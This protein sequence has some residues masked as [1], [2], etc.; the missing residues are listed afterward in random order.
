MANRPIFG[1]GKP[2][3]RPP[4][5]QQPQEEN[6][7]TNPYDRK[8]QANQYNRWNRLKREG[9]LGNT[10][11]GKP[12]SNYVPPDQRGKPQAK[13]D[14]YEAPPRLKGFPFGKPKPVPEPDEDVD[15][16]QDQEDIPQPRVVL[17]N[18]VPDIEPAT[19]L[20]Q[21]MDSGVADNFPLT[22]TVGQLRDLLNDAT[23]TSNEGYD[24]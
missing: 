6:T 7:D 12:A 21:L 11:Y 22:I 19:P 10:V 3:G 14:E 5:Q 2:R 24:A 13:Q 9:K 18:K 23:G 17:G 1:T 16:E 4:A 8:T 20:A 15:E